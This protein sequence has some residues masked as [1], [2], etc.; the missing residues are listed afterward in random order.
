MNSRSAKIGSL[1]FLAKDKMTEKG[2]V[3]GVSVV[4]VPD[5]I[6]VRIVRHKRYLHFDSNLE[7]L[8]FLERF[9]FC[10]LCRRDEMFPQIS[11]A[12]ETY[13]IPRQ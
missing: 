13:W 12:K 2:K 6:C 5:V 1:N 9:I 11:I 10:Q 8:P 3:L 4:L 7:I